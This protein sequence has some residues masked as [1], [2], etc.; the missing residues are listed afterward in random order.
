MGIE[1]K[2]ETNG[3]RLFH[4]H[5]LSANQ[6]P[7]SSRFLS[8]FERFIS[9]GTSRSRKKCC[10]LVCRGTRC[11]S[12]TAQLGKGCT[13]R[14]AL[15]PKTRAA[16]VFDSYQVHHRSSSEHSCELTL[17]THHTHSFPVYANG[18][19]RSLF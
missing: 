14:D 8:S 12:D 7:F 6:T 16:S 15:C 13:Y 17:D 3:M 2:V 1:K 4:P 5:V 19:A 11:I 10:S 18:V 9:R